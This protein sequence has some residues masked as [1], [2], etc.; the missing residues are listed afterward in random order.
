MDRT[1]SPD[2]VRAFTFSCQQV[3]TPSKST[4]KLPTT[5]EA[6]S[7]RPSTWHEP[8][9]PSK[10]TS[11][12]SLMNSPEEREHLENTAIGI[13]DSLLTTT[14]RTDNPA[15]K[16]HLNADVDVQW[17]DATR[18]YI[19]RQSANGQPV[20]LDDLH[21][22]S[23]NLRRVEELRQKRV[24]AYTQARNHD[25]KYLHTRRAAASL[26]VE[27]WFIVRSSMHMRQSRRTGDSFAPFAAYIF[28]C[29]RNGIYLENGLCIVPS[30][31]LISNA[32]PEIR[33]QHNSHRSHT[34]HLSAHKGGN[35]F[36]R[37]I[38]SMSTPEQE[39]FR[40]LSALVEHLQRCGE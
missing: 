12:A 22:F 26:A 25:V 32:L 23:I 29:M 30:C 38:A 21:N 40:S 19:N 2:S 3:Y 28:F 9:N 13:L 5:S 1:T 36:A 6:S 24:S 39:D 4:T 7:N 35:I 31:R 18:K 10:R 14:R 16:V 8:T 11:K 34:N 37:S 20:S 27:I 15:T 33:S 17:L